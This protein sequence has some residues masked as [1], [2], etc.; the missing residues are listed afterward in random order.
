MDKLNEHIEFLEM[1]ESDP[2]LLVWLL[3]LRRHRQDQDNWKQR[4]ESAEANLAEEQRVNSKLREDRAGLARECNAFETKLAEETHRANQ[5]AGYLETLTERML[6][7]ESDLRL[8]TQRIKRLERQV[9][10][11]QPQLAELT[12]REPLLKCATHT[13][14]APAAVPQG[15]KLVPVEPNQV[16]CDIAHIGID[17]CTGITDEPEYYSINGEYAAKVYRAMLAAA[18]D[19]DEMLRRIEGMN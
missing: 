8:G 12:K 6:Q 2:Q 4:A 17:P 7:A 11:Y 19:C 14:S 16:M 3:E 13:R 18:P 15:W 9:I 1:T 5:N 10:E